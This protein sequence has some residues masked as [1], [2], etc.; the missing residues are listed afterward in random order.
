MSA[1]TDHTPDT[2][3]DVAPPDTAARLG[4]TMLALVAAKHGALVAESWARSLVDP[5]LP[6]TASRTLQDA[7][8]H[9][10]TLRLI[11]AVDGEDA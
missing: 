2:S 1:P 10:L 9:R 11:K 3:A 5:T 8:W 4:S 7:A 6:G